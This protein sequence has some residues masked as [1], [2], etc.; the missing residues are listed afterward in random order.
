M[1]RSH[2]LHHP[3]ANSVNNFLP[4]VWDHSLLRLHPLQYTRLIFQAPARFTPW[5]LL[6]LVTIPRHWR[7][8]KCGV[9]CCNWAALFRILGLYSGAQHSNSV[10]FYDL[11]LHDF[12]T[13]TTLVL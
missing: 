11:F 8:Q 1:G 9:F 4:H 7:L 3:N 10:A 12:K 13:R 6:F 5:L 2:N